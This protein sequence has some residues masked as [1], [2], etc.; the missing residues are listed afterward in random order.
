MKVILAIL[1]IIIGFGA[2]GQYSIGGGASTLFQFGNKKPFV[3]LNFIVEVPRNNEVTFYGRVNY[4][5]KQNA[6][7]SV[8][9]MDAFAIDPATTPYTQSLDYRFNESLNYFMI[10]GGTRYYLLNGFDEG[11]ALYGGTNIAVIINT[12]KYGYETSEYDETKYQIYDKDLF[13]YRDKGTVLNLAVGFTGGLKY[14]IPARGTFFFDFNPSMILFGL[15]S[16][17]GLQSELYKNVV[18]NF[19]I[20]YRK[21]FY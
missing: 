6:T 21:E 20:G 16:K 12:I 5:F 11:F 18:F 15:P 1:L 14:T 3:G 9:T 10:D 8:G 19:N 13:I 7:Q 4:L 2:N 17:E